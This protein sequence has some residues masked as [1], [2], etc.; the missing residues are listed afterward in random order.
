[1]K[2]FSATCLVT[3]VRGHELKVS[4]SPSYLRRAAVAGLPVHPGEDEVRFRPSLHTYR[5][6]PSCLLATGQLP[7][8]LPRLEATIILL[9]AL[10][11]EDKKAI[12]NDQTSY[13]QCTTASSYYLFKLAEPT[14]LSDQNTAGQ[15]KGDTC[16]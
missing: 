12:R 9:S 10:T 4:L 11:Q 6:S 1:M 13:S 16:P 5:S 3:G 7:S 14:H 2:A 15:V 8:Q